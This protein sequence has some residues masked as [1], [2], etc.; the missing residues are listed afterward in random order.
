MSRFSLILQTAASRSRSA[1][2]VSHF[3]TGETQNDVLHDKYLQPFTPEW[4]YMFQTEQRAR[5]SSSLQASVLQ[6][7]NNTAC[8]CTSACMS[9]NTMG[10]PPPRTRPPCDAR[11]VFAF[12]VCDACTFLHVDKS[13]WFM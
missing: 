2:P 4:S 8:V 3:H 13:E 10:T 12:S 11:H 1:F 9:L 7:G 5:F 6:D